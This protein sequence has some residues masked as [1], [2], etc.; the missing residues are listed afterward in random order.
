MVLISAALEANKDIHPP[1]AEF[2][3]MIAEPL[4]FLFPTLP[5]VSIPPS[6]AEGAREMFLADPLTWHGKCVAKTS[7]EFIKAFDSLNIEQVEDPLLMIY[8]RKVWSNFSQSLELSCYVLKM[9][10]HVCSM[11]LPG[12]C[13]GIG[14]T[15]ESFLPHPK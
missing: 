14:S 13:R 11:C 7:H 6:K 8:G 10:L 4:V 9:T 15:Q 12:P 3:K 5:L 1:G 2:L